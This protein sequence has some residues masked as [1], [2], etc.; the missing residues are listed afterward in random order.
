MIKTNKAALVESSDDIEYF[1]GWKAEKPAPAVQRSLFCEMD[2]TEKLIFE[3]LSKENELN[4]DAI[5]RSLD[6]P[7]HKLSS[8]L[9][10]M[11]F[12]GLVRFYPGNL[13]RIT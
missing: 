4:I 2:D 12:R 3:L 10:Q 9:L 8:I 11:E 7:V 6:F 13:Y 5:S 1:L